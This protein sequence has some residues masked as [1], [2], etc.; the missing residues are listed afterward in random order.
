MDVAKMINEEEIVNTNSTVISTA[1]K[2]G[3]M[4]SATSSTSSVS[5]RPINGLHEVG[6][7][8]F[9][10]KTYEMVEDP[11]TDEVVSWSRARNSFIVWDSNTFSTTLL[12]KY[13]KHN[14][15]SSFIRQLNTYGFRKVDADKWEFA[16]ERFLGGQKHLLKT[17]KRRRHVPQSVQ[18]HGG[19]SACVE[20]GQYGLEGELER[21]K[22]DRSLLMTAVMRLKQQHQQSRGYILAMQNRLQATERK[23]QQMMGFLARAMNNPTF[24]QQFM[25]ES[26]ER[27]A[28]DGA[29]IKRKR[30]LTASTSAEDL[31]D[32]IDILAVQDNN[33]LGQQAQ[34]VLSNIESEI[35]AMFVAG[36]ESESSNDVKVS[37]AESMVGG[38]S[39]PNSVNEMIWEELLSDDLVLGNEEDDEQ[40]LLG[41][42]PDI[43]DVPVE[44]L[45]ETNPSDW[46][47]DLQDLV[48]QLD[49]LI[50]KP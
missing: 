28:M 25:V 15:F 21:L 34:D 22:R 29:K 38:G 12:P 19:A 13:F 2:T 47:E 14:N 5:P 17:I 49:F 48:D 33:S 46:G 18:Q 40:L 32:Q 41:D 6:P 24:I 50:S 43:D 20:V 30:R 39:N 31:L 26:A 23:Q 3:G 8:P 7:P 9:L 37:G 45:E 1:K 16:N 10:T 42:L 36:L 35:D 27:K 11:A 44:D 4:P